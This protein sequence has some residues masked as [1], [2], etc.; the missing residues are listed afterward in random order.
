MR[1]CTCN[2]KYVYVIKTQSNCHWKEDT[3]QSPRVGSCLALEWIVR[4]GTRADEARD[5]NGKGCLGREQRG[6]DT[7]ENCSAT[8]LAALGF[9]VVGVNFRVVSGQSFR[10]R[11]LCGGLC[12]AQ[13]KWIPTRRIL[14]LVGHMDWHPLSPLTFAKFFWSMVAC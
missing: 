8:W 3:F 2:K 4:G 12:I 14:G 7:Q 13:S 9:M 1:Q 11:V 6:K 5:F 10:L